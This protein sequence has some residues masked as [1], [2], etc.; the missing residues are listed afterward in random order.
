MIVNTDQHHQPL[1][2]SKHQQRASN[3]PKSTQDEVL[4]KHQSTPSL[5]P[6]A[7]THKVTTQRSVSWGTTS[8]SSLD[9]TASD[10]VSTSNRT[11]KPQLLRQDTGYASNQDDIGMPEN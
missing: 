2:Y 10:D 8:T 7:Q 1:G 6:L 9:S 4:L 3:S 11:T 5:S